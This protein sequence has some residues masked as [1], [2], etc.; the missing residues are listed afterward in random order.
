MPRPRPLAE[1]PIL[2][3][4]VASLTPTELLERIG[5]SIREDEEAILRR[6]RQYR[7]TSYVMYDNDALG[8]LLSAAA[9][10]NLRLDEGLTW[11]MLRQVQWAVK[12][13]L[14]KNG[15]PVEENG[16]RSYIVDIPGCR[17]T[18]ASQNELAAHLGVS[19]SHLKRNIR[20]LRDLG[21][22]VM[23]GEGWLEFDARLIWKGD[24]HFRDAYSIYQRTHF[25][26]LFPLEVA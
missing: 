3:L 6:R 14:H 24:L 8:E 12:R 23:S 21:I 20:V 9:R 10:D 13:E 5:S 2:L 22:V 15:H 7:N 25:P 1:S 18:Y 16:L 17:I 4:P 19:Q 26:S 11:R